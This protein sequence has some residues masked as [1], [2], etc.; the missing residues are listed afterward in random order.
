MKI[1]TIK[2][3]Y[4]CPDHND[5][6]HK[7]KLHMDNLLTKIGF[8]NIEFYKSGTQNYPA[9]LIDAT[10]DILQNNLDEPVILLEDDVEWTG[11]DEIDNPESDAIYLGLS[12]CA[13]HPTE[14]CDLGLGSIVFQKWS[15]SQV[16]IL[17]MLSTHA[18]LYNS[19]QY[20]LA[21]IETL[22]SYKNVSYYNDVLI[23]RIQ[24]KFIVL[25]VKKPLFYQ[26]SNFNAT[27]DVEYCTRFEIL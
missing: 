1:N 27:P 17:N 3:I 25:G 5:K 10:I 23:S 24:P 4:I 8:T 9:C 20:K 18:I 15:D 26:S 12:K 14:N 21:V 11:I 7:R 16:R 2:V 19:R 22:L 6:Y 13:G